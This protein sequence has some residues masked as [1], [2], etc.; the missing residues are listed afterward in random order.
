[1]TFFW[2]KIGGTNVG[3]D[4]CVYISPVDETDEARASLIAVAEDLFAQDLLF[5]HP[6]EQFAVLAGKIDPMDLCSAYAYSLMAS[7]SEPPSEGLRKVYAGT[8]QAELIAAAKGVNSEEDLVVYLYGFNFDNPVV[9][10]MLDENRGSNGDIHLVSCAKPVE[11]FIED[12]CTGEAATIARRHVFFFAG[13]GAAVS[14]DG[15]PVQAILDN[16]LGRD[17]RVDI[18]AF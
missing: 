7:G 3:V 5:R 10:R 2:F 6:K 8:D 4:I 14:F 17:R 13:K 11:I 1:V 18:S 9:Q 12:G 16:R 15:S